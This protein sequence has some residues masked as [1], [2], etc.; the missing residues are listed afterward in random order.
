VRK[1]SSARVELAEAKGRG[2]YNIGD[3]ARLTGV[4]AKMIRHYESIGLMPKAGRTVG[5]YRVYSETDLHTLRFVQR[6]RSLGFS[7]KQIGELLSL[8]QNR[9]RASASVRKLALEH[10]EELE[11]KSRA[12]RGMANTLRHLAHECRGDA[13]P[14]CPILD[15][16]AHS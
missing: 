8:W 7:M 4:S 5:N 6:A 10:V 2:L 9:S 12:L 13:R 1:P 14:E 15:D 3:A 11:R 16:L